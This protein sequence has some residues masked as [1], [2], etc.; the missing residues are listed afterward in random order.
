[1]RAGE[2]IDDLLPEAGQCAKVDAELLRGLVA[3]VLPISGSCVCCGSRE[4]LLGAL[5]NF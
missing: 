1:M 5:E 3:S 2:A 4:E